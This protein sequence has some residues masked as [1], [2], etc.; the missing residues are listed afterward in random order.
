MNAAGIDLR[1]E[2]PI[3]RLTLARAERHNAFDDR[4]IAALIEALAG[5]AADPQARVLIIAAEGRSFSAGADLDWM[6]R[7]AEADEA[8][9]LRD[10][11]QLARLLESLARLPIPTVALVQGAAYGGGVGLVAACDFAIASPAANFALSEV[12]LGLI[13]AV[14]SP[15]I[16]AAI[17]PRAAKRLFLS[18]ERIDAA[19]ALRLG[20]ITE[21]VAADR[22][23]ERGEALAAELLANA[24]EAM[25]AVKDLLREVASRPLDAALIEETAK[26]IARQRAGAEAREGIAAF[27]E[28]RKPDWRRG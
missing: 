27:L 26:R 2:G 20:L 19:E 24:P 3:A 15:Y 13:P 16:V 7:M 11:R 28:K 21:I 22:L 9:N 23:R 4:L 8:A 10:A 18:A 17:G 14:I 1:R 6:R 12:K 25:A 5:I